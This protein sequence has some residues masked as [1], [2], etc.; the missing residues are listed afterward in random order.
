MSLVKFLKYVGTFLSLVIF[1]TLSYAQET[2]PI[3][4]LKSGHIVIRAKVNGVEGN[5]LFDTGGGITLLTKKFSEK[6][7]GLNKQDGRFTGFRSTGERLD[8]DL[9][10]V[11]KITMGKWQI[12]K[13]VISIIDA[14]LASFDGLISLNL[15][16]KQ[17]FT[18]DL[19]NK[20]LT[21]ESPGSLAVKELNGK[22]I[23]LQVRKDR[24]K[25][26]DI[27]TYVVLNENDTLQFSLDSGAGYNSFKINLRYL[28]NR[29][30][31]VKVKRFLKKSEFDPN[32]KTEYFITDTRKLSLK[33]FP[34]ISVRNFKTRY[35]DLIY[36]GI[37]SINSLG[38]ILTFDLDKERLIIGN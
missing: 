11:E 4:I 12:N 38:N 32:Y 34:E 13:P 30:D 19:K 33:D 3:Q 6:V 29:D 27:F 14:D 36:D 23:Q 31:T 10:K 2:I 18:L 17:P 9:Y 37:A 28:K 5:F 8:L 24:D 25:S 7:H 26:I 1:T 22:D 16:E 21:F 20:T 35:S 15:F